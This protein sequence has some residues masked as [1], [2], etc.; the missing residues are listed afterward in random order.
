MHNPHL[1]A[2]DRGC[3]RPG[4]DVPGYWSEVHHVE[5]WA[6][7]HCTDV[8]TLTLACRSD[9]P[10]VQPDGWTTRKNAK[11][12]TEWIPQPTWIAANA[13]PTPSGIPKN[14]S[15]TGTKTTTRK[16]V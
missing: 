10:L 11:G 1:F 12:D 5:D 9:H 14:S 16:A 4:C 3:T 13:E 8:N 2:K 15:A 6:T 7:T